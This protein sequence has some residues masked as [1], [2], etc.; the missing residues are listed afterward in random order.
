MKQ[1]TAQKDN[2]GGLE[3]PNFFEHGFCTTIY[4][5]QP[6][7]NIPGYEEL[8]SLPSSPDKSLGVRIAHYLIAHYLPDVHDDDGLVVEFAEAFVEPTL[9]KGGNIPLAT[10]K[11]WL[12]DHG[13]NNELVDT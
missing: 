7:T 5:G 2:L 3:L 6:H 8:S 11:D 10:I 4:K 13:R 1:D 12:F 9:S